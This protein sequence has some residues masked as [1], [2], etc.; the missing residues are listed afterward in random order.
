MKYN[1]YELYQDALGASDWFNYKAKASETKIADDE[2]LVKAKEV[3]REKKFNQEFDCDWIANIEGAVYSDVLGKMEDKKQLTR[4]PY[5][6]SLP[7]STAWDLGVSDHR[8][9]IF[10]QQLG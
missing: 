2:E 3:M 7:V 10:Y 4:V 1:F 8:S 9:I 5:D 6:P